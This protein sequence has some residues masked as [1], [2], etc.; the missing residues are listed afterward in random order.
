MVVAVKTGRAGGGGHLHRC[1]GSLRGPWGRVG[2]TVL[3]QPLAAKDRPAHPTQVT[4]AQ[5]LFWR[6][7]AATILTVEQLCREFQ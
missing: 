2:M 5:V 6:L 4:G 1:H 3:R 7:S